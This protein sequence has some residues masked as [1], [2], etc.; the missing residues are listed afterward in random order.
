MI[1]MTDLLGPGPE[2]ARH[3]KTTWRR[4]SRGEEIVWITKVFYAKSAGVK[5]WKLHS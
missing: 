2:T 5:L 1:P 4:A 3:C